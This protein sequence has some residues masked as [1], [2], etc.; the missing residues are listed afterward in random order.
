LNDEP[1]P[2]WAL[3]VIILLETLLLVM[4]IVFRKEISDDSAKRRFFTNDLP[5]PIRFSIQ[6]CGL[7]IIILATFAGWIA[8]LLK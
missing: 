2:R 6:L 8:V 4:L 3:P 7:S 1:D 5:E